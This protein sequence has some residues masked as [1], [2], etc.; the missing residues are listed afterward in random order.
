MQAC[1]PG[2]YVSGKTGFSSRSCWDSVRTPGQLWTI[3]SNTSNSS[4]FPFAPQS[5]D[6]LITSLSTRHPYENGT[7]RCPE[8]R[9]CAS[10]SLTSRES[11]D[12][13]RCELDNQTMP[14]MCLQAGLQENAEES[15]IVAPCRQSRSLQ[16]WGVVPLENTQSTTRSL[17]FE[18][19]YV[20]F[21]NAWYDSAATRLVGVSRPTYTRVSTHCRVGDANNTCQFACNGVCDESESGTMPY[22]R[23]HGYCPQ[24]SDGWDCSP[25]FAIAACAKICSDRADCKA[26]ATTYLE[27]RVFEGRCCK[28][29]K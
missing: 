12:Q 13:A 10:R 23:S 3:D 8:A 29:H 26:F 14:H 7:S 11:Q 18:S 24:Y 16:I 22:G 21:P 1:A 19:N 2:G 15:T 20:R 17:V 27:N 4:L 25:H 28:Y 5:E 9:I 6:Y